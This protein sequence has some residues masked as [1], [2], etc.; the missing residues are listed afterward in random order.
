MLIKRI[1]SMLVAG[2]LTALAT[3][4]AHA[5]CTTDCLFRIPVPG[6]TASAT[7][8]SSGTDPFYGSV[9]SL[10]SLDTASGSPVVSDAKGGTWAASNLSLSGAQSEV[11]SGSLLFNTSTSWATGP[12]ISLTG[13]FTV[14]FW[15]YPTNSG[16]TQMLLAQWNQQGGIATAGWGISLSGGTL[17][18]SFGPFSTVSA[19]MAGGS[20]SANHWSHIALTRKGS[21]FRE[22]VNGAVVASASSTAQGLSL[23]VPVTI[24][25]YI[26]FNGAL[27]A[28]G[29]TTFQGY[30]QQIRITNGVARYTAAFTPSTTPDPTQ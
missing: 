16:P 11:G 17:G 15:V 2:A 14:E 10:L 30:M 1:R 8:P 9:A 3:S 28:S 7:P 13:D 25:N 27:P 21:T 26:G 4:F 6:M 23:S 24:G 5:A 19:M 18:F 22:F 29:V 20:V 12:A